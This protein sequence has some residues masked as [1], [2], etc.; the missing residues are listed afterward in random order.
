MTAQNNGQAPIFIRGARENNLKK[1]NLEIPRGKVVVF[2]GV[3]GSGKSSIVFD[4]IASESMRQ[5][6]ETFP[7]YVRNRMPRYRAPK[8]DEIQNLT[9][10]IVVDQKT[11]SG[12]LRSTVGTMTDIS[13][14]LRL[15]FSR[16]S[17]NPAG[18]SNAY[19]FNDP[20][21]MCPVCS[22][23]GKTMQFNLDKVLDYE[24]SLNE[25]AI[26]VPGFHVDSW[27]WQMYV[28]SGRF[29]ND[30]PLKDFTEEEWD[31]FLHGAGQ[32]VDIKNMTGHVWGDSYKL[33]FEGL[34][35]RLDRLFLQKQQK[36]MSKS[37]QNILQ[38]FT[39]QNI[40]PECGGRRLSQKALQSLIGGKNIWE[41]GQMEISDLIPE[42]S[43]LAEGHAEALIRKIVRE[44]KYIEEIGLGYL[45]LNRTSSTLSGGE[46]QRLKIVRHLG[47]GL[48][49]MTYIFD[50]PSI[51]LHPRDIDRLRRLMK[52]LRDRG[53]TVL[54]VEH[55]RDI[56]RAADEVIEVG[57]GA[58]RRGG[59]L[60]YQGTFDGL[61]Q[62]DT[63]TGKW[64]REPLIING[65]PR[66][67]KEWITLTGCRLNNLKNLTVRIPRGVLTAITG[68]AGSG[69]SSLAC[70][71]LLRQYPGTIHISQSPV[72]T[73]IRSN[74]A[75]Y[76]G[77]MNEI[78][79]LFAKENNTTPSLYSYN[80]KG[81][82]PV[83]KGKG[84]VVTEMAYMD[85]VTVEC[86]VCGGLRYNEEALAGRYR[87]K[88]IAEVL[89]L[90]VAEALEF[91]DQAKIRSKLAALQEVG[92]DYL[93]LGQPTSTMS[94]GECQ[95]I[96]LAAHLRSRN[97]VYVMDEPAVGLH[98]QDIKLLLNLLNR[99]VENGNTV[100]IVE[101]KYDLISK[102]DWIIDLGPGGGKH[103]GCVL[104]EGPVAGLLEQRSSYTGQY[105]RR[106]VQKK[107]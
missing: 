80:A 46:A 2:A 70:G 55:D 99:L 91:F 59:T 10:A 40:C 4:T 85:P 1:I 101:H 53:N 56:I 71:E 33:T 107:E 83:C 82:C 42:L 45:N 102:A 3:S 25:G 32:I 36:T 89:D 22:G 51:G 74:P 61:T 77:I 84:F 11:V 34:A 68:V 7:L 98:G 16:F 15:L 52:Q 5:L 48:T 28:R 6:Y 103:G 93:T 90:T 104:Y 96:K 87:G 63:P 19:S 67:P 24:K 106:A 44:L 65:R 23:L 26:R 17:D 100:V 58:G 92:L 20:E 47:S 21:G 73:N 79:R 78:R 88:T 14:M 39:D 12:D 72:G 41:Y 38:N 13:P 27:Q 86:E 81:A 35:D 18:T 54:V 8:A 37:V 64:L 66:V 49:G 60:V 75:S 9:T 57:P 31:Y 94:G 69:K 50:E 97:G 29:D 43:G 62:A 95:R 76:V 105:L 30:K